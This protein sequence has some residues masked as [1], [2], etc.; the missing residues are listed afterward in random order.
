M[1]YPLRVPRV[2]NNDDSA[3][4]LRVLAQKGEA[5]RRGAV[6][7]E[8]E[9]D[10]SVADVE[11]E[12]DGYVLQIVG[13]PGQEVAVGGVLLWLGDRPD[14]PVPA[15]DESGPTPVAAASAE[16]TAKAR[17]LLA[18]HGLRTEEVP[19]TGERLTVADVEAFLRGVPPG[20][21]RRRRRSPKG[22]GRSP[23]GRRGR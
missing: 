6:V 10:K 20:Q 5:V 18:E 2:N 8:I 21:G 3:R 15:A 17:A 16:P 11:A 22:R 14:E 9:T 13:V 1:P 12:Q 23:P 4:L 19:A 7:A